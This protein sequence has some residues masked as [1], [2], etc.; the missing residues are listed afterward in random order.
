MSAFDPK[1]TLAGLLLN[2]LFMFCR[3]MGLNAA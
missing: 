1:P 2:P 3:Q